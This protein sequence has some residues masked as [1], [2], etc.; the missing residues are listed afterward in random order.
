[1]RMILDNLT[2]P[3][4]NTEEPLLYPKTIKIPR[5]SFILLMRAFP[6]VLL[7]MGNCRFRVSLLPDES[8]TRFNEQPKR[9]LNA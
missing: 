7:L 6:Q 4:K 9:E 3:L 2:S 5:E 8:L 1:M